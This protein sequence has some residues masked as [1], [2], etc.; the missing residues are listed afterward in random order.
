MRVNRS[1]VAWLAA[2]VC[3]G[4]W[5]AAAQEG[6]GEIHFNAALAHL[7]DGRA[8]LAR[9]EMER[10][11]KQDGKNPYFRKGLAL[12]CAVQA[13]RCS[14]G[15]TRCQQKLLEE[16]V[17]QARKALELNPYF[18]DAR[19]DLGTY[20]LRLGRRDEGKAEILNAFN[21]P[22]NPTAEVSARNLGQAYLE[23]G[24]VEEALNWFK[25]SLNRNPKYP[26][27]HLGIA[28]A[29]V[30]SGRL[31]AAIAQLEAGNEAVPDY[32]PLML[33]LG[34]AYFRAGRF[35]E[36]RAELEKTAARDAAGPSG[37]QA[38]ERLRSFPR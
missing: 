23:E 33:A 27:A 24:Q 10:A 26:D 38:L 17:E 3:F 25:S 29:Y 37:R 8:E 19:N 13:D 15:D 7:R 2:A 18:V 12:A 20:L 9:E 16:A 6:E 30:A 4:A 11:V 32:P 21:D 1:V 36:A 14:A 31:D 35:H 22:T 28:D 5:P 34:E